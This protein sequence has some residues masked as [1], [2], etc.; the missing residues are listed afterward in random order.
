MSP[1]RPSWSAAVACC[2]TGTGGCTGGSSPVGT[3]TRA[4]RPRTRHVARGTRRPDCPLATP[5]GGPVLIHVDVHP[6]ADDH[7]HLD[8]RYLLFGPDSDPSRPPGESQEVAWFTWDEADALADEALAG[9]LRSAR[10][11]I[12]TGAVEAPGATS[13]ETDG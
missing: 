11:L 9:A 5:S 6:A 2:S 8:V 7:V 10:R 1:H 13:E 12:A 4:S 3:S